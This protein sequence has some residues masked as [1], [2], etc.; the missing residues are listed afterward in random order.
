[1]MFTARA[2]HC[3][4]TESPATRDR[5]ERHVVIEA[6]RRELER[7]R[8][9]AR[10]ICTRDEQAVEAVGFE[11]SDRWRCGH[12]LAGRLA[13]IEARWSIYKIGLKGRSDCH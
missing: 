6:E 8:A 5:R 10:R 12:R 13:E 1:M 4:Q 11:V 2:P 9:L 7:R 3:V